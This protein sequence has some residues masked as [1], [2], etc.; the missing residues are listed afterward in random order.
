[1]D[2]KEILN[3][4]FS[5]DPFGVLADVKPKSAPISG[6]QR[7]VSSF[8]E[9]NAFFRDNQKK[10]EP[11]MSNIP[12]FQLY[13][14]LQGIIEDTAKRE[15]LLP[16]D[17]YGL[18][19]DIP[20]E[21]ET[22]Q[23]IFS[24]DDLGL[25]NDDSEG[26]YSLKFVKPDKASTD[27][28]ARR[29]PCRRFDKYEPLF[30]KVQLEL[31]KGERKLTRFYESHLEAG[32]YFVHNG[33]LLYLESIGELQK[34]KND[35]LDGRT[36]VIFEN[37]TES[38]MKL[39]SLGKNLF[40]NGQSVTNIS[41]HTEISEED[42]SSGYIYVLSSKSMDKRI[43]AISDLYKIGFSTTEVEERIKNAEKEPTYLMSPV[44]IKY[45]WQ[46][47]NLNSHKLEQLL[48][49]FFGEV[50]LNIE[51]FDKDGNKHM[52]KEWFIAP[53]EIIEQA[54][55]LIISGKVLNYRYD[56]ESNTIILR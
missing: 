51:I 3:A 20:K 10:P 14:R 48:H 50:C 52:P 32:N 55:E 1:M 5:D 23:D 49:H 34:D 16:Y 8:L 43:S 44:E 2:K 53:L 7:L 30:K 13:K 33:I 4:I 18:L 56:A 42:K 46:C 26:L 31:S 17:E 15:A 38:N 11:N 45:V 28:V 36:K 12:E 39:R 40:S 27:F 24:G 21:P 37:G 47:Y 54:I 6:D 35:K 22:M 29:K 25:L 41:Q 9:I 19:M